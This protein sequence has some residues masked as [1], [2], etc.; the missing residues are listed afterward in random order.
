MLYYSIVSLLILFLSTSAYAEQ[1]RVHIL[2]TNQSNHPVN[3]YAIETKQGY[4]A[5]DTLPPGPA[6]TL[7]KEQ[8][9][10]EDKLFMGLVITSGDHTPGLAQM[11]EGTKN[12]TV[13]AAPSTVKAA[14]AQVPVKDKS[15][16]L[17]NRIARNGDIIRY[18]S[19]ELRLEVLQNNGTDRLLVYYPNKRALF[20]GDIVSNG[21]HSQITGVN[22]SQW[23]EQLGSILARHP[24]LETIYPYHGEPGGLLLVNHQIDYLNSLQGLTREELATNGSL[25]G[26]WV[27]RISA[28]MKK[29]FDGYA[30]PSRLNESIQQVA[31]EL[32]NRVPVAPMKKSDE[33]QQSRTQRGKKR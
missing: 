12:L 19:I 31:V 10:K 11:L 29:R 26:N 32:Q 16:P 21:I 33:P 4:I 20:V 9:S 6:I 23:L 25:Q 8:F 30:L 28:E 22:S 5:I 2:R 7:L 13:I 15:L 17:P 24:D 1:G 18:D 14:M 27:E 3:A